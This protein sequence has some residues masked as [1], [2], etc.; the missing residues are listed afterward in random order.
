MLESEIERIFE[1]VLCGLKIESNRRL[2]IAQEVI[3]KGEF[4][5]VLDD[6]REL[7]T[8]STI[9]HCLTNAGYFSRLDWYYYGKDNQLRPDITVWLPEVQRL[10]FFELKRA[11]QGWSYNGLQQDM[12][13]L[14]DLGENC[15]KNKANGL[16]VVQFPKKEDSRDRLQGNL[17]E[18]VGSYS[19]YDIWGP[20]LFQKP[21]S[22]FPKQGFGYIGLVYNKALHQL[23]D[24]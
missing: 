4:S 8:A 2:R 11:G 10:I 16:I 17:N 6:E 12:K 18:L 23:S 1:S 5:F 7:G 20:K 14:R 22:D 21:N 3:K 9:A 19:D 24:A 13:K 15:E